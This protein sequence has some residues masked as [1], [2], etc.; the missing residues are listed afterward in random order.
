LSGDP[1]RLTS[2]RKPHRSG[3]GRDIGRLGGQ[4]GGRVSAALRPGPAA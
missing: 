1:R 4:L 2:W 3:R